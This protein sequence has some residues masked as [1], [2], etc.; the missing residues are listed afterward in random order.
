MIRFFATPLSSYSAKV[1]IALVFKGVA[2][3]ELPPPG[4][5]RSAEWRALVPTGTIPAIEVDGSLL[6]ESEAIIEY[7]EDRYAEPSLLPGTPMQRA[8]ARYL[9]RLHDLSLEPRVRALF[10]LLR[11]RLRGTPEVRAAAEALAVQID[12]LDTVAQPAPYLA[13]PALTVADCG[14]VV[15]VGL[16]QCLLSELGEPLTL[17]PA[18]EAWLAAANGH[19]AVLAALVPWRAATGD[20][21]QSLRPTTE[22]IA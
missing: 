16:G 13:G 19:P 6:A 8:H 12:L 3:E 14:M 15:S 7:L 10:P 9:A 21:L 1:R 11:N 5:Y 18:V 4:G 2:F 20:W 22:P 17:P